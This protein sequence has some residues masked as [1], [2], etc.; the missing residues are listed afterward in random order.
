MG[1]CLHE[2]SNEDLLKAT[3]LSLWTVSA[4]AFTVGGMD[5]RRHGMPPTFPGRMQLLTDA[6]AVVI[7][8]SCCDSS[9]MAWTRALVHPCPRATEEAWT[10]PPDGAVGACHGGRV[11]GFITEEAWTGHP[12]LAEIAMSWGSDLEHGRWRHVL[13]VLL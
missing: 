9:A 10:P 1:F 2:H 13:R 4:A 8:W 6:K 5:R 12:L 3:A 7:T 11:A